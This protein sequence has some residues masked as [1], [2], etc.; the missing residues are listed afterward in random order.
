MGK[1]ELSFRLYEVR[2]T[3]GFNP[4]PHAIHVVTGTLEYY[5]GHGKKVMR[6]H[7]YH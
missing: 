5:G 4:Q 7:L 3:Y 6:L 1:G 2:S